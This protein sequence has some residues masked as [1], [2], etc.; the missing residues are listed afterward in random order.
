MNKKT[1]YFV[2]AIISFISFLTFTL[3]IK[4]ELFNKIDF[5]L[6]LIIQKYIP[7]RIDPLLSVFSLVGSFEVLTLI[8]ILILILTKK[9]KNFLIIIAFVFGHLIEILGKTLLYHPGP[10]YRFFRY[11]L[12]FLFPSSYIQ[13][14]SSYPS[15]HSFRTVF[16][17]VI[18]TVLIV[19]SKRISQKKKQLLT[20]G[21]M[22]FTII[23]LISRVSLGEHWFSDVL[24]GTLLGL[25]YGFFSLLI[26]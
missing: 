14:S 23:M 19:N 26:I 6:A 9:V 20:L 3:L 21:I 13:A 17:A 1:Y 10:P 16:L 15:G 12:D 24:G 18:F 22:V 25:S 2:I 5:R 11:D 4:N 8:L 7:Q